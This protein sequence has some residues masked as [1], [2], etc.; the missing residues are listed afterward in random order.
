M[1]KLFKGHGAVVALSNGSRSSTFKL[2][3]GALSGVFSAGVSGG[4]I[5]LIGGVDFIDKDIAIT[6]TCTDDYRLLYS[7]GKDFGSCT[8][9]G[10]VFLGS[11]ACGGGSSALGKLVGAFNSDRLSNKKSPLQLSIAGA[12][13]YPVYVI[14]LELKNVDTKMNS[15]DF[16]ID[17]I[18]ASSA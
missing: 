3:G 16:A 2:S 7:F 18:V 14:Q 10:T 1:A 4:S 6:V 13:A 12:K 15:V 5:A 11:K 8:I 17:C 9:A